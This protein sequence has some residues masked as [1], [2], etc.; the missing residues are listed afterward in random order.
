MKKKVLAIIMILALTA[1]AC[2]TAFAQEKSSA[3]K[4]SLQSSGRIN[5]FE[6][7]DGVV[8]VA[9]ELYMLAGQVGFF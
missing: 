6:G 2:M 7:E 4:N 9:A 3:T 5:Y 8:I 1:G